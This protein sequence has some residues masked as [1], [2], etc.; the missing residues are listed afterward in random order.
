[1]SGQWSDQWSLS[2]QIQQQLSGQWSDQWSLSPQIQQQLSG[3]KWSASPQIQQ[4]W[5]HIQLPG[6]IEIGIDVGTS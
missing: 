6:N 5:S 2:P 3:H 1:L 4:Q